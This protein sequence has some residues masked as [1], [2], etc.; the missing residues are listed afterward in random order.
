[1][2]IT[3]RK[4]RNLA[5]RDLYFDMLKKLRSVNPYISTDDV[6]K[7][8][9]KCDAPRFY[10]SLVH[11]TRIISLIRRGKEISISNP[12]KLKM[13]KT[14]CDRFEIECNRIGVVNYKLLEDI[15]NEKAPSFFIDMPTMRSIVYNSLKKD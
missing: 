1:M 14:L 8:L 11:A 2:D 5:I 9:S 6:I 3:L 15:I 10:V 12:N 13:Y 7:E 4:S